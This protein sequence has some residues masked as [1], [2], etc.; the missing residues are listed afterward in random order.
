MFKKIRWTFSIYFLN[1]NYLVS[2][3]YRYMA[4]YCG[5]SQWLCQGYTCYKL[6]MLKSLTVPA[7]AP[8]KLNMCSAVEKCSCGHTGQDSRTSWGYDLVFLK[9]NVN[10]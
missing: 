6:T 5:Y 4:G 7:T 9:C 8:C 1:T 3:Q 2:V 10:M